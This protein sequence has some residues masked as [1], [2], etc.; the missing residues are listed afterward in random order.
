[1]TQIMEKMNLQQENLIH[2]TYY[3]IK[4]LASLDKHFDNIKEIERIKL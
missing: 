3:E 1:M 4:D 2:S